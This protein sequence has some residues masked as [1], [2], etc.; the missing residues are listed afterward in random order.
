MAV[1]EVCLP[2]SYAML[3]SLHG[4]ASP[5]MMLS[6]LVTIEEP[7]A[8]PGNDPFQ[9]VWE[10]DY[11]GMNHYQSPS[12]YR[13]VGEGPGSSFGEDWLRFYH[14]EDREYVKTEWQ[15]SLVSE[16][17][18]PYDIEVRI[19]RHDG[20]FRWFR[21]QGAPQRGPDGRVVKWTG[22]C[23][24]IHDHKLAQLGVTPAGRDGPGHGAAAEHSLPGKRAALMARLRRLGPPGLLER[25]LFF[26][27]LVGLLPLALL[28][29]ATLFHNAK[30]QKRQLIE[31]AESTSHA[32][33]TAVDSE[34]NIAL[35]SLDA[36]SASGRLA[37]NDFAGFYMEAREL[38]E[39]RPGWANV[40]LSDASARQ[41]LNARLPL[42][43]PL[44]YHYDAASVMEAARTG[45]T[46]VGNIAFNP[47]LET[48][49]FSVYVPVRK[50]NDVP[51]V[52]SA[53]VR[54]DAIREVV[55]RQHLPQQA[56][57]GI[58][59]RYHQV[60]ARSLNHEQR[61]G[62][63][64]S[65]ELY[66]LM[67][68][69][70]D[71]DWKKIRTLEGLPV[72]AVF[73]R[74]DVTGWSAAIGIPIDTL[75][76][77]ILRSYAVLGGA[78][79]L[80]VFFGL[81]A[82]LLIARTIT[83]PIR[84]LRRA[85]EAIAQG[86][87]PVVPDTELPEIQQ[88]ASALSI[89]HVE[90]E[91]RLESERAARHL[92]QE[93]RRV[94]ENASKAKD[95]FL[96]MLGHELRNPLA[97]ITTATDILDLADRAPSGDAANRAKAIIRR[98]ARHLARLT[99]DLL[100]AGRVI[101]GK[102]QLE[103]KPVNLAGIVQRAVDAMRHTGRLPE[104]DF[105]MSLNPAW[106]EGDATRLE[107]VVT[108][109]LANAV[110]YTPLPGSIAISTEREGDEAVLR[111]RDSGLG[112]DPDL[113]PRVFDLFVQ[114]KRSLDRSQG[115]LG[116]GLTLVRRLTEL[117]GGRVEARSEGAGKGSEFIVRLPAIGKPDMQAASEVPACSAGRRNVVIVED[118]QDVRA[119]LRGLL[120]LE[121]HQ[122]HEAVD[123]P[124]GVETILRE[125]ADVALIDIGL[126]VLDGYGVA[127]AVKARAG[128][129]VRLVAMTGYGS[130]D[131][132][133]QGMRAGF[134]T[135]LVKPV[136]PGMLRR[137]VAQA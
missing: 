96:A 118:N 88:V 5:F 104:Y 69:G 112:L 106:V 53:A 43:A 14:P 95:E 55:K 34:L 124:S 117:H 114:G 63:T 61:V 35:A 38:L 79:L 1:N 105:A 65:P 60:V 17:A 116:I 83:T 15:K 77:P 31:A 10:T 123:G 28:S 99:D 26:I 130:Q 25:R 30:D 126:P 56:I 75:D 19:R 97:A 21:V 94:A 122:V 121:G 90:R 22:T 47:L 23:T 64:P 50:G 85:A 20:E 98:Q 89:A 41:I 103:R 48:Y 107:Q 58:Y 76:M 131:D 54:P 40:V 51:Y 133:H 46:R 59:D 134:D 74:S 129:D 8:A 24:D 119:S 67:K 108:N 93:A 111:V 36:L 3:V 27:V 125:R 57:V 49:A 136:D 91:K 12:W 82:A 132:I 70:G 66:R 32:I 120:E 127:R 100:D 62:K 13:Y 128:N 39:R 45:R 110:K 115:G 137:I 86:K 109:L 78:I 71:G 81:A 37:A 11:R 68:E 16:G 6:D 73:H 33:V 87:P 7:Q 135:Y 113:L 9:T 4:T 84:E 44:P 102:I 18:H 2:H 42:D 101:Q 72:Y 80:S 92:E 52:L 29:F